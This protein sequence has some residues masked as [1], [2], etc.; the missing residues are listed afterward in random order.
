MLKLL[1]YNYSTKYKKGKENFIADA[2][3]RKEEL[4]SNGSFSP[5]SV[6]IP[7]WIEE[8]KATYFN[9]VK[10]VKLLHELSLDPGSNPK[11]FLVGGI[12]RYKYIILIGE[13]T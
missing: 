6:V 9:D 7:K 3:S 5:I 10:C 2:L 1:K 12:L 4:K 11:Y 8:A 13:S